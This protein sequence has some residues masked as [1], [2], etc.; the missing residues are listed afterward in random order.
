SRDAPPERTWH[1]LASTLRWRSQ[2]MGQALEA[3]FPSSAWERTSAKLRFASPR[4]DAVFIRSLHGKQSFQDVR[5][6]A[7]L[8]NEATALSNEPAIIFLAGTAP[9]SASRPAALHRASI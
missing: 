7:E 9:Y 5:S 8:G 4:D 2:L 1:R 6:Q 3:S